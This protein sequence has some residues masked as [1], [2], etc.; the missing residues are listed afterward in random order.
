MTLGSEFDGY[1]RDLSI[2][3]NFD[4]TAKPC[5]FGPPRPPEL[6]SRPLGHTQEAENQLIWSILDPLVRIFS[7]IKPNRTRATWWEGLGIRFVYF[8]TGELGFEGSK[9]KHWTRHFWIAEL[10]SFKMSYS[11]RLTNRTPLKR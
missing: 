6:D 10:W 3:G 8:S 11:K 5:H 1:A 9:K 4:K 7:Q 2:F